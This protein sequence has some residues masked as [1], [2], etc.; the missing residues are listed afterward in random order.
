[1]YVPVYLCL[2]IS[3]SLCTLYDYTFNV[4]LYLDVPLYLDV[5]RKKGDF[6]TVD[7]GGTYVP[8]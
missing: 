7:Y 8:W 6:G 4:S 3:F 5:R 1:M 2:D